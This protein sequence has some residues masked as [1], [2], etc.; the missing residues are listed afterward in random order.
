MKASHRTTVIN[1]AYRLKHH[2]VYLIA[3][4]NNV[5]KEVIAL[6]ENT[7]DFLVT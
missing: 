3:L 5:T 1:V 2:Y 6:R 7:A 4:H